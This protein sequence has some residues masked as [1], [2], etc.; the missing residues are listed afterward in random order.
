MWLVA[1]GHWLPVWW[2][3]RND[4]CLGI[5]SIKRFMQKLMWHN[6]P[7][8]VKF[9]NATCGLPSQVITFAAANVA[10]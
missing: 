2:H 9:S 3:V 8:A 6:G 4:D 7:L 1:S 10:F 5:I